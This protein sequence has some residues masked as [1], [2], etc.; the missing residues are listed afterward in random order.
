M[1][2]G[3]PQIPGWYINFQA[4]V[5]KQL[6]RPGEINQNTSSGWENNQSSLKQALAEFLCPTVETVRTK[7]L[8]FIR[9]I[10]I[11]LSG[12]PFVVDDFF[13]K[14]DLFSYV[15]PEFKENFGGMVEDPL[16]TTKLHISELTKDARGT[17]IRDELGGEEKSANSL[18]ELATALKNGKIL[19][20]KIYLLLIKNKSGV[21]RA[22]S[23]RWSGDGWNVFASSVESPIGW[24]A[25]SRVFARNS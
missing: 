21:L 15:S 13:K 17:T 23:V 8:N 20:D 14:G 11:Q 7:I 4:A 19:E 2:N 25:G 6:P 10:D 18:Q 1:S 16:T 24:Y 5:L 3:T 9:T 12:K 22:V